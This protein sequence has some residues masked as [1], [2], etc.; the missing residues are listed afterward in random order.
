MA[1]VGGVAKVLVPDESSG[2]IK[3]VALPW[4]PGAKAKDLCRALAQRTRITNP[5]DYGLF[6]L[7]D[8][9]GILYFDFV[10]MYVLI[11]NLILSLYLFQ[12]LF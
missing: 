5:Q 3:C 6:T 12:K 1:G 11:V 7:R 9:E 4:R 2:A 10:K 8:G